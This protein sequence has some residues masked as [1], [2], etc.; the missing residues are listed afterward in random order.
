MFSIARTDSEN[1]D[2]RSLVTLLNAE[3]AQRDGADHSFYDQFNKIDAL[4]QVVVVYKN[5]VP[6]GCGA[7]KRYADGTAEVKR[8]FVPL[9]YRRQG[10]AAMALAELEGWA[11]ESGYTGCIL[12]TGKKQPEAIKLYHKLGYRNI[13]NYGP[14]AGVDNSVCMKKKLR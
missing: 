12:E 11:A 10:I 13:P 14:Y 3:L 9:P 7:I 5:G 6:V 8:M 4:R 1:P 2:F